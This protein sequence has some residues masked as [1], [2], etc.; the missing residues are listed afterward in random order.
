MTIDVREVKESTD[1]VLDGRRVCIVDDDD[2]CRGQIA[3]LLAKK[4]LRT[5]ESADT[6]ALQRLLDQAM[7]DCILLDYDLVSEN[8]L[9]VIERLKQ[10]YPDLAPIVMVSAD[11]TQ[12]TAIRAFRAGATDYVGKRHLS[13]DELTLAVRR[14]IGLRI[15]DEA[16]D[17]ELERLRRN[18]TFDE[19]T[20]L[21]TRHALEERMALID[22]VARRERHNYGLVALRVAHI[23]AVLDRFGVTATDR[24]LRAFGTKLRDLIRSTDLCGVWTR[25]TFLYVVDAIS[26]PLGFAAIA[27]RI[28]TQADL[29]ID[30]ASAHLRVPVVSASAFHPD[31]AASL[32]GL[33]AVLEARL[34]ETA[35]AFRDSA[36]GTA[37]WV[38]VAEAPA[39]T[40]DGE[41]TERRREQR[42]RTLKQGRIILDG[43]QSTI[44]CTVRNLSAG[45]AG[46]RLMGPT[47]VPEFFRLRISD[48]GVVRKVRKCWQKNNDLGVEFL[49][50]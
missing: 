28:G 20:G 4:G 40:V 22:E 2:L 31:D 5:Q 48:G 43:L 9:F 14:A 30:L 32:A 16:R 39:A 50:D 21:L 44:D 47:V 42:F 17:L 6:D 29:E 34:E 37:E 13:G 18:A 45:G 24:I 10:R 19:R 36:A 8:G 7:P 12:R 38:R 33:V 1:V 25:G 26:S 15:R 27:K 35:R 23:D 49:P 11:E 41:H 46:L 3:I